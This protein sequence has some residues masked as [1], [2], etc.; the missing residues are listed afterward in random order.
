MPEDRRSSVG[1]T[2]FACCHRY[3]TGKTFVP[4]KVHVLISQKSQ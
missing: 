3:S 2:C 1:G 4:D